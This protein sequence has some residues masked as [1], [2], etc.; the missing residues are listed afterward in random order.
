MSGK[1][2]T[3]K[4]KVKKPMRTKKM[5]RTKAIRIKVRR[6]GLTEEQQLFIA[7][8]L[9]LII[10]LTFSGIPINQAFKGVPGP[11]YDAIRLVFSGMKDVLTG[12]ADAGNQMLLIPACKIIEGLF[13]WIVSDDGSDAIGRL[14]IPAT[15][16]V[17]P[18]AAQVN[19]RNYFDRSRATVISLL[20]TCLQKV[21]A[22]KGFL[23]RIGVTISDLPLIRNCAEFNEWV[24]S[25]L[26]A[27]LLP[28][29]RVLDN[30]A[31]ASMR[32]ALK[33]I[34]DWE[35]EEFTFSD[36]SKDASSRRSFASALSTF[37]SNARGEMVVKGSSDGSRMTTVTLREF[38]DLFDAVNSAGMPP[39]VVP[40]EVGDGNDRLSQF[41]DSAKPELS[42]SSFD[43]ADLGPHPD[44]VDESSQLRRW[45]SVGSDS[46][47]ARS[48]S[49]RAEARES[50]RPR[51]Y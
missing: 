42:Q 12:V 3:K 40:L 10:R 15:V 8:K 2:P 33:A 39:S 9:S 24:D 16:V 34:S 35:P 11:V 44:S 37:S 48:N 17:A 38:S 46:S 43:P 50:K 41:A 47:L 19:I 7:R 27:A 21:D 23:T 18:R 32:E 49:G 51:P 31:N 1:R 36:Y 6:G 5:R 28:I 45:G 25:I 30:T 26:V 20:G 13:G 22:F 29:V 4:P 14:L